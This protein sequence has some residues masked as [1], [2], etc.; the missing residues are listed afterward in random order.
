MDAFRNEFLGAFSTPASRTVPA[1][2][3]AAPG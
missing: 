1:H 3:P 2:S